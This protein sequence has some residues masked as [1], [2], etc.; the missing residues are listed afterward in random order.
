MLSYCDKRCFD[1][2]SIWPW[3]FPFYVKQK[4][5]HK[6]CIPKSTNITSEGAAQYKHLFLSNESCQ[7]EKEK[8]RS[9]CMRSSPWNTIVNCKIWRDL[10]NEAWLSTQTVVLWP[11]YP[12]LVM[13]ATSLVMVDKL[14]EKVWPMDACTSKKIIKHQTIV[15]FDVL[16]VPS[17]RSV[18][19]GVSAPF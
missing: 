4:I 12:P 18:T 3:F 6:S 8:E 10:S 7:R 9:H 11:Q 17:G 13:V 5:T 15:I 14:V 16:T 19:D 1:A 2:K